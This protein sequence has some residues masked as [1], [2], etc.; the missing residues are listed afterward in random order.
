[1]I[2]SKKE[3]YKFQKNEEVW[4]CTSHSRDV[5]HESI[6]YHSIAG[7]KRDKIE[8][9]GINKCDLN[10]TFPYPK[11]VLNENGL[12]L[13]E[14]FAS[15]LYTDYVTVKVY[16][17]KSS[18][19]NIIYQGRVISPKIVTKENTLTLNCK[20]GEFMFERTLNTPVYQIPCSNRLYGRLCGLKF[21]DWAFEIEITAITGLTVYYVVKPT[22]AKDLE[23]NLLFE[24]VPV[25]D[26]NNQPVL[27]LEGNPVMEDGDPIMETKSYP[28]DYLVNGLFK[29]GGLWTS[30][31]HANQ[32][33]FIL[34]DVHPGIEVGD[35]NWVSPGCNQNIELC[36]ARFYN[37]FRYRG[38]PS[39]PVEALTNSMVVK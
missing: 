25:L 6:I 9:A 3:L 5:T 32:G 22:Q 30:I 23:G 31:V 16:R 34:Y 21:E 27:D 10:L 7:L 28:G 19:L 11:E 14:I 1:M 39:I 8:D 37:V 20:T 4:Y 18:Q 15:K 38:F 12:D 26:E 29:R 24:Q 13:I 35:S 2:F 36:H 17:L 33:S